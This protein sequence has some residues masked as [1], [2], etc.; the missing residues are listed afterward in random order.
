MI[1]T[2]V[3]KEL[4]SLPTILSW[5]T[6]DEYD[7]LTIVRDDLDYTIF[8]NNSTK[9]KWATLIEAIHKMK[10]LLERLKLTK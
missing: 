8:Y 3:I 5:K 10:E 9:V 2:D 1:N 6:N 4:E 7:W